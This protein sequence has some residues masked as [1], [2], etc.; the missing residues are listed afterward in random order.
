MLA[1]SAKDFKAFA[2]VID[3]AAGD[4]ARV[5]AVTSPDK[6]A[7]VNAER[8]GFW[9]VRKVPVSAARAGAAAGASRRLA[10]RV[11]R[12]PDAPALFHAAAG[13]LWAL[14]STAR[15]RGRLPPRIAL[16]ADC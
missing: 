11:R 1:T 4:A 15:P 3:A 5:V 13:P 2:D 12:Q 8:P 10:G 9:E 16:F 7:G 6:A 14:V